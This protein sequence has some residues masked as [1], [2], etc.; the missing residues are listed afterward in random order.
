MKHQFIQAGTL[1]ELVDNQQLV[2]IAGKGKRH[3]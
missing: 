1:T 2:L 3:Q